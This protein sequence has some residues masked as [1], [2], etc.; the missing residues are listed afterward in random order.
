MA[1]ASGSF[2]GYELMSQIPYPISLSPRWKIKEVRF[3]YRLR[4]NE[5]DRFFVTHATGPA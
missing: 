1:K 2:T 3:I 5:P 4:I